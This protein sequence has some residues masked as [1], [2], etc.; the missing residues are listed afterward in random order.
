VELLAVL[1]VRWLCQLGVAGGGTVEAVAQGTPCLLL[2]DHSLR[3]CLLQS[4][5][6]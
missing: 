1:E 5:V 3:E 4:I 2:W 6:G